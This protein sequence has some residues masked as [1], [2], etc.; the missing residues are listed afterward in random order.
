MPAPM[1]ELLLEG[2][3]SGSLAVGTQVT[4]EPGSGCWVQAVEPIAVSRREE[5]P[6][7]PSAREHGFAPS[8]EAIDVGDA[9]LDEG[10]VY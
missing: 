6:A 5:L 1:S 8:D 9:S 3:R 7:E 4:R 2:W 10:C